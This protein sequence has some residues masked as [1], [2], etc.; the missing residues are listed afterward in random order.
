VRAGWSLHLGLP[1]A[2]R[3]EAAR[4]YWQAFGGKLGVVLGPEP[5][6]LAYLARVIRADNVIVALDDTGRLLG[7]AGFKTPQGGFASGSGKDLRAAYGV[8]GGF[9]RARLLGLL[10]NEVDNENFL[11]DGICVAPEMRGMGLGS[12]LMA[13]ICA[14]A[15]ARGYAAVRLEVIDTNWRAQV[16]YHRLGFAETERHSIG[17]LRHV[18]GFEAAVTMICP[19]LQDKAAAWTQ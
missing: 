17:V 6:A 16:L 7:L 3:A 15:R 10:S 18:F 13:A 12:A 19:V 9:W 8:V 14:E 5:R 2:L 4:L 11:L 1:T